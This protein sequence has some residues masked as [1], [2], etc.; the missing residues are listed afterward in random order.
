MQNA[1]TPKS[2]VYPLNP[3]VNIRK[4][5]DL[6]ESYGYMVDVVNT[7]LA[8]NGRNGDFYVSIEDVKHIKELANHLIIDNPKSSHRID[9]VYRDYESN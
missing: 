9:V 7:M 1:W 4:L 6:F 3:L 8:V 2:K 5:A